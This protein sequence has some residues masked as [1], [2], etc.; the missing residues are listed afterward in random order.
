MIIII[1]III[2]IIPML[3]SFFNKATGLGLQH[4]A[5]KTPPQV[6]S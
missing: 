1:I 6:F 4:Y 5:K 2:I 3:V